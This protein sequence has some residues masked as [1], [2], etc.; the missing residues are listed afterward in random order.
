MGGVEKPL[1]LGPQAR[2]CLSLGL[3]ASQQPYH[4]PL[5]QGEED[6]SEERSKRPSEGAGGDSSV[7]PYQLR[8]H[9]DL[10]QLEHL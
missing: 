8:T 4:S 9:K 2:K 3:V 7:F 1:E 10:F 5:S 6:S